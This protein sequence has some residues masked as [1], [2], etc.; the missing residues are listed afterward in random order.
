MT[1]GIKG[2][3][4]IIKIVFL[5]SDNLFLNLLSQSFWILFSHNFIMNKWKHG[6]AYEDRILCSLPCS[7]GIK[8]PT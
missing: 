4:Q 5:K 3:I 2:I 8:E 7:F 6:V 1:G